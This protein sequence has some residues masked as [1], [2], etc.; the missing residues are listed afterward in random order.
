[1]SEEGLRDGWFRTRNIGAAAGFYRR[2]PAQRLVLI[3]GK[4]GNRRQ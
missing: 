1:L 3:Y 2:R 4:T